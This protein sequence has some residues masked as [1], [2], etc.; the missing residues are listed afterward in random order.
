MGKEYI[1]MSELPRRLR[2]PYCGSTHIAIHG[3]RKVEFVIEENDGEK[4]NESQTGIEWEV[5]YGVACLECGGYGDP[6]EIH[7]WEI[8]SS[9]EK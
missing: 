3:A 8:P 4:I 1:V 2:C 7:R 9:T 6:D 5:V